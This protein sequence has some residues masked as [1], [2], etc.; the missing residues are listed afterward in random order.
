MA[1]S[2]TSK[3]RSNR[4]PLAVLAAGLAL[5]GL[6]VSARA[7]SPATAPTVAEL[8][9]T[10]WQL[11]RFQGADGT[12]LVPQERGLYMV[13]FAPHGELS[14]RIDCNRASGTWSSPESGRI[15]FGALATTRAMCAPG[16]F[17]DQ[18]VAQWSNVRFYVLKDGHLFLTLTAGGTYEYE[19]LP[20]EGSAPAPAAA[21]AK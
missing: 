15:S 4:N 7:Q 11:V 10:S 19:P 18:I 12:K 8:E 20:V 1:A 9:G 17:Y 6:T 14:A 2:R 21:P 5:A 16:S 3:L 13:A